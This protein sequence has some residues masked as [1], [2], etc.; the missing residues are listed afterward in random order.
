MITNVFLNQKRVNICQHMVKTA[1][2]ESFGELLPER[3]GGSSGWME[4]NFNGNHMRLVPGLN[5]F[6][7]R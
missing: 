2:Q 3:E 6:F 4:G 5:Q 1:L 7:Q